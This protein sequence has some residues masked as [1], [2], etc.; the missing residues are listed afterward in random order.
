MR[1]TAWLFNAVERGEQWP[2][3]LVAMG[4]AVSPNSIDQEKLESAFDR[5]SRHGIWGKSRVATNMAAAR[6]F[7]FP[8][9]LLTERGARAIQVLRSIWEILAD[10]KR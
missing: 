10:E 2:S 1:P 8:S 9:H 3:P 7:S 4:M 6:A 5:R